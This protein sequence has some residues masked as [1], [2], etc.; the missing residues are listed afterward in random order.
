[1]GK[2][3]INH[4]KIKHNGHEFDSATEYEFYIYHKYFAKKMGIKEI[5]VQP[6]YELEPE[7]KV[8]C[9]FCNGTGK[10]FNE[11]TN[12]V[13][14][15]RRSICNEGIVTKEAITYRPDFKFI[16]EDGRE[17]VIDVKGYRGQDKKFNLK[18][19]LFEAKFG[20]ELVMVFYREGWKWE[21]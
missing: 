18:K 2:S 3:K 11:K 1:M 16:Y 21:V 8:K 13:N 7:Y 12:R 4:V 20:E 9:Y 14:K 17:V 19:R 5:I 6:L 15:C 10:I